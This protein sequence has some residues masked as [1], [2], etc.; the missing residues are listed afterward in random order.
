MRC[1]LRESAVHR[2]LSGA[3]PSIRGGVGMVWGCAMCCALCWD[4]GLGHCAG[5]GEAVEAEWGKGGI[6]I[7]IERVLLGLTISRS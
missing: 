2:Q 5:Q 4:G 7:D 3:Y 1:T 6:V